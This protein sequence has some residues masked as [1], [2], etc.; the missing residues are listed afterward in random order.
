[1]AIELS[2]GDILDCCA[3][4]SFAARL[5]A[6]G[7]FKDLESVIAF[8]RE[9]WWK[10]VYSH[11]LWLFANTVCCP[12]CGHVGIVSVLTMYTHCT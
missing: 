3:S 8:S 9:I 12:S 6:K 1:M 2:E 5:A 11:R 4:T 10:K 7:P